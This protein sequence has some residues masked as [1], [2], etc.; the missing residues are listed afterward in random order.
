M[1]Y[2]AKRGIAIA[3]RLSVHL[4]VCDVG[5]SGPHRL[6]ISETNFMYNW[7]NTFALRSPNAIHLLAGKHGKIWGR[8]QVEWEKLAFWS[9]K[10]AISLKRVKIEEKLP[11]RAYRKSPTLFR[12]VPSTTPYGLLFPKIE[13]LQPTQNVNRY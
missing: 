8:L 3:C 10:A 5:G 6:E 1:H 12:T 4:S 9:T 7:P 11:W 13:G 2:S